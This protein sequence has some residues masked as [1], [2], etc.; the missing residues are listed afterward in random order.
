MTNVVAVADIGELESLHGAEL[1]LECEEIGQ[2]L[3]GMKLVRKRV[4]DGNGDVGSHFFEDALFVD[5]RD[6][7]L[8]PLL[9]IASDV[10][11]GLALAEARL[12]VVEED[13][14]ATHALNA[15]L[16]GDTSAQGRLLKD[17][18]DVLVAQDGGETRRTGLDVRGALQE[19]A[20]FR[21]APIRR[22]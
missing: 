2:R 9:E 11:N 7:A 19:I 12:G 8:H 4:D 10:G 13:H 15:D 20:R 21:R 6:D 18:G 16:K 1:F 17:Q 22:R 3:A 5:A 14:E